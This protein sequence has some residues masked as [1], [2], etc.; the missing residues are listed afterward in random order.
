M[1]DTVDLAKRHRDNFAI[2]ES[3]N[4]DRNLP[5]ILGQPAHTSHGDVG[6]VRLDR[7]ADHL[8]DDSKLRQ[9]IGIPETRL[10]T[11]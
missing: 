6:A 4:L 7:V 8:F 3:D 2:G 1:A 10:I 11:L 9:W 5:V